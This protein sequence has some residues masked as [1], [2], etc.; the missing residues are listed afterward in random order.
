MITHK[1]HGRPQGET[2]GHISLT[3]P[4]WVP[5]F[6]YVREKGI[7]ILDPHSGNWFVLISS[8]GVHNCNAVICITWILSAYCVSPLSVD[9]IHISCIYPHFGDIV[10]I[11]RMPCVRLWAAR[12]DRQKSTQVY[13]S[14]KRPAGDQADRLKIIKGSQKNGRIYRRTYYTTTQGVWTCGLRPHALRAITGRA[15]ELLLPI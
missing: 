1:Q 4:H 14:Q 7:A 2:D 13:L 9:I 11:C 8:L 15:N 12:F 6:P 5:S 10:C 3:E